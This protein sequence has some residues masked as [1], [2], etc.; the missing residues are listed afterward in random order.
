MWNSISN[1]VLC[2]IAFLWFYLCIQL[3]RVS[4]LTPF[5]K[6]LTAVF[7]DRIIINM[8]VKPLAKITIVNFNHVHNLDHLIAIAVIPGL[9]ISSVSTLSGTSHFD[10]KVLSRVN[11]IRIN[12]KDVW[13]EFREK[14]NLFKGRPGNTFLLTFFE[15]QALNHEKATTFAPN[16]PKYGAFTML[17]HF[18]P[19]TAFYDIDLFYTWKGQPLMP[20]DASF[21]WKL[22]QTDTKIYL[23]VKTH[24]FPQS[25]PEA[26][27]DHLYEGKRIY[28]DGL[29]SKLKNLG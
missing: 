14:I 12:A 29:N 28:L 25:E 19:H 15:G 10:Q 13:A 18:L 22:L 6:L 1:V 26:Y 23:N 9:N 21:L 3:N 8:P 17:S 27:L 4:W 11:A 7:Q 24:I 20:H 2:T 5:K 16:K